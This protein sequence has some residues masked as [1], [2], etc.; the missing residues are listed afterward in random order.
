MKITVEDPAS[1]A[2]EVTVKT[3]SR[4]DLRKTVR[5]SLNC[6]FVE[7]RFHFACVSESNR[8]FFP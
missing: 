3:V 6:V 2:D 5:E 8:F 1:S 4:D 7:G